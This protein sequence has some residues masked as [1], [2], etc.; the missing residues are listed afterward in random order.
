MSQHLAFDWKQ[1]GGHIC[2]TH[3]HM[4]ACMHVHMHAHIQTNK[5]T[6]TPYIRRKT[7]K[8]TQKDRLMDGWTDLRKE[9]NNEK[10]GRRK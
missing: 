3:T 1:T 4:Y 6:H 8:Q 7:G 9:A 10:E 2:T 5:T